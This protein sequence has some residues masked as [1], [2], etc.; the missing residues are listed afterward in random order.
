[1]KWL[2]EER[3]GLKDKTRMQRHPGSRQQQKPPV[4]IELKDEGDQCHWSQ[5]AK[6]G[7][8]RWAAQGDRGHQGELSLKERHRAEAGKAWETQPWRSLPIHL[9]GLMPPPCRIQLTRSQETPPSSEVSILGH[10]SGWKGP[11][12]GLRRQWGKRPKHWFPGEKI[13]RCFWC[14][15]RNKTLSWMRH[16]HQLSL[17]VLLLPERRA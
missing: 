6:R 12:V 13:P 9:R 15:V 17:Q 8:G 10:R 1:M 11:E 5:W 4:L 7:A 14:P 2:L 3:V 16:P